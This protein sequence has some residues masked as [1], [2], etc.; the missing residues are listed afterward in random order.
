MTSKFQPS[1]TSGDLKASGLRFAIVVSRFNSF[2]TE[3][4]LSAAVDALQRAGAEE[5]DVEVVRVPGAFELPL[6]A[7]K[8]AAT[9]R[10]DSLIAIGCVLRGETT[11][12][13][14]VCSETARGLQLAQMDTGLPIIFCV[15]TCD[16]LEQAIDRA[17]LKGGNKG[18]EAGLAAIEMAQLSRKLGGGKRSSAP[19][20]NSSAPKTRR[21]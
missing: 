10:Y 12:Y 21:K 3:R 18:F 9:G 2:L 14:Y 7:K 1:A 5:K 17:G 8:L 4:L 20:R 13:D 16:T 6:A 15:L 19:T 11:H